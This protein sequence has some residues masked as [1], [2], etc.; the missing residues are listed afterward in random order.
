MQIEYRNNTNTNN[1][2]LESNQSY[3]NYEK[4]SAEKLL[5]FK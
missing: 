4:N 1:Y 2:S 5:E 3:S